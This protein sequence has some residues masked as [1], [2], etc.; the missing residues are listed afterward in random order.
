MYNQFFTIKSRISEKN[1]GSKVVHLI[2]DTLLT[3]KSHGRSCLCRYRLR[4]ADHVLQVIWNSHPCGKGLLLLQFIKKYMLSKM[5]SCIP[6]HAREIF[7]VISQF[8][9]TLSCSLVACLNARTKL[10]KGIRTS[11]VYRF[12]LMYVTTGRAARRMWVT[13]LPT[14][15]IS[16]D[17]V[18][19][20]KMTSLGSAC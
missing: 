18:N 15:G 6:V 13:K 4:Q 12:M 1:D 2:V 17:I 16:R 20:R 9:E 5:S 11:S 3:I 14:D 8:R 19:I 10:S 7:S